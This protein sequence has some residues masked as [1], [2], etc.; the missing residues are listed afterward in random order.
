M[1]KLETPNFVEALMNYLIGIPQAELTPVQKEYLN[2]E[3]AV[4]DN[5]VN[6]QM[7]TVLIYF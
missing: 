4:E 6:S 2:I 7:I 3:C 1:W 5:V